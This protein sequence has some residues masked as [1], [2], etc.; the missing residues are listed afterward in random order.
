MDVTNQ[1]TT[2]AAGFL[3]RTT[4]DAD[5]GSSSDT[6]E[7]GFV[8]TSGTF[9]PNVPYDKTPRLGLE[10]ASVEE[11]FNFYNEYAWL[12]GFSVR[13]DTSRKNKDGVICMQLLRCSKAGKRNQRTILIEESKRRSCPLTRWCCPAKIVFKRPMNGIAYQVSQFIESHNHV[14]CTPTKTSRL[15]SHKRVTE[16]DLE[17][18]TTLKKSGVGVARSI[19]FMRA[20]VGGPS[21]LGFSERDLRNALDRRRRTMFGSDANALLQHFQSRQREDHQ[22]TYDLAVDDNMRLQSC[23]WVDRKSKEDYMVFG[24]VICFDTTY[25]TNDYDMPFGPFVGVNHHMQTILFGAGL[26]FGETTED[27]RWLFQ[28]WLDAMG[29][30]Q[31]KTII[32]DQDPAIKQ[33]IASV[34]PEAHHMLCLWHINKKL[35][36]KLSHV[37]HDHPTFK[38]KFNSCLYGSTSIEDFE[39]S[40][41]SM[42]EEFNLHSNSWLNHMYNIRQ[43]WIP[44]YTKGIFSANMRT[45]G[46][47]E[48]INAFFDGFVTHRSSLMDFVSGYENAIEKRRRAEQD[49]DFHNVDGRPVLRTKCQIEAAMSEIYTFCVFSMFQDEVEKSMY[50]ISNMESSDGVVQTWHVFKFDDVGEQNGKKVTWKEAD[51]VASCPCQKFESSGIICRHIITLLRFKRMVSVPPRHLLQRWTRYAKQQFRQPTNVSSMAATQ[52]FLVRSYALSKHWSQLRLQALSN[53]AAYDILKKYLDTATAEIAKLPNID[54]NE[55]A[56][57][58][59]PSEGNAIGVASDNFQFLANEGPVAVGPLEACSTGVIP[60]QTSQVMGVITAPTPTHHK[61]RSSARMKS[62]LE[63]P[64]RGSRLCRGCNKHVVG[65]DKRTCPALKNPVNPTAPEEQSE[66]QGYRGRGRRGKYYFTSYLLYKPN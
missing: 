4:P 60:S 65:H 45:T 9:I 52:S 51:G 3:V 44:A 5:I 31:P 27:F 11:A 37:I 50:Y 34:F 47:S 38:A 33:A 6:N 14:L 42:M 20:E 29:G 49:A 39:N 46:R 56:R 64:V 8:N 12:G 7:D 36:D 40:W 23:F 41:A 66:F 19:N 62:H 28:A 26:L 2:D 1:T 13:K 10:F 24:D 55:N 43:M 61:G 32:T 21:H 53:P 54:I 63:E 17:F 48:S 18:I 16:E 35:P 59:V 58:E 15:R 22:F 30:V 57:N 25:K